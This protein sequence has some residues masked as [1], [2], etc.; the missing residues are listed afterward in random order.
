MKTAVVGGTGELGGNVVAA[1][2]AH[3][4][5]VVAISRNRPAPGTPAALAIEAHGGR[6]EHRSADIGS[7]E[8]L[9]AALEGVEV[10]VNAVGDQRGRRE[11]LVEGTRRLLAA[12][13]AAG[14]GHHVA[15]SIV[16]CDRSQVGYHRTTL[17]QERVVC[18]GPVPWT[19]L[20]ATQFHS[21]VARVFAATARV[22][23]VPS[24]GGILQPID[25]AVVAGRLADAAL[26]DPAGRLSDVAGPQVRTMRELAADWRAH[27]GRRLL[28]LPLPGVGSFG[29]ALRDGVLCAPNAAV[30][31]PSFAQWLVAR[32]ATGVRESVAR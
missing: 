15:I 18:D 30:A 13:A 21:L 20:R 7:G 6:V 8:G 22:G 1:L 5:E 11:V 2:A 26:T 9:A 25:P 23:L 29:R 24:G 19:V 3:G 16:G 28:P 27:A 4:G 14:G 17:E 31:G 10:V 12:E 32:D